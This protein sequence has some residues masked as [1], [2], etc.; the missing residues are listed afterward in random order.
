MKRNR[1]KPTLI[2][3]L[4]PGVFLLAAIGL[5]LVT[6]ATRGQVAL[7]PG[8]RSAEQNSAVP[9]TGV[10]ENQPAAPTVGAEAAAA[11]PEITGG[12]THFF[13][14]VEHMEAPPFVA[15][16]VIILIGDGMGLEH[17]RAG[18]LYLNGAAGSLPFEQFPLQARMGT[19]SA[20]GITDS[21][22]AATA[23][24]TAHKV[25]NGVLSMAI[26]GSRRE[27]RTMLEYARD[28]QMSTGLVTTTPI[29]DATP[30]AFGAH[31]DSRQNK[32]GIVNDYLQGSRP[33][34]LFGGGRDT[35]TPE[36]SRQ[37][38]YTVVTTRA[39]MFGLDTEVQDHV[40][41][42][43]ANG[44]IP[45][46]TEGLGTAPHLSEMAV[47]ML[48]IL[49]NDP[50][51]FFAVIEGGRI[52]HAAH[53]NDTAAMLGE[54]A[55][56]SGTVQAALN[57]AEGRD[58]T[59]IIVLADHETGGLSVTGGGTGEGGSI[60]LVEWSTGSHTGVDVGLW[61]WSERLERIPA[62]V[63]NSDLTLL[64]TAGAFR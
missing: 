20:G 16:N 60:P 23:M 35:L 17:V 7:P 30:A 12:K 24:A 58:D 61:L 14:I 50:D 13:P 18:G 26:P 51:G 11:G 5:I 15:K 22:A 54:M 42:L 62:R 28:H 36:L 48:R 59:L 47:T 64:L 25:E 63:E 55:E 4:L 8:G 52:D 31:T 41:G 9:T 33:N 39:D 49:D 21:A 45:Y 38:G 56:F 46:E 3:L 44:A 57:W 2:L 34:V 1:S 27:Y 10:V 43:F 37:A 29:W 40:A 32:A 53:S 19:G 6:S